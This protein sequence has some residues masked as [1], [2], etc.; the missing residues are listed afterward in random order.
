[1]FFAGFIACCMVNFRLTIISVLVFPILGGF[2]IVLGKPIAKW[3]H[4]RSE[5]EGSANAA[6]VDLIGGYKYLKSLV[7]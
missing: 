3:S 4:I 2:Q 1:M 5:S 6:F 7:A